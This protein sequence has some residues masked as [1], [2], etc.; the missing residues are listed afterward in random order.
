MWFVNAH[1]VDVLTGDLLRRRAVE[2]AADGTV[3]QVTAAAPAGLPDARW[4][5]SQAAGCCPG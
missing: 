3:V 2:T 1:V 5:M 4:S